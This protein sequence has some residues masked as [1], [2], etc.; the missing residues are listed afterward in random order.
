MTIYNGFRG[1]DQWK[2]AYPPEYD[3]LQIPVDELQMAVEKLGSSRNKNC[4]MVPFC[5]KD[6][7]LEPN[8]C[9]GIKKL[10]YPDEDTIE[11]FVGGHKTVCG[12]N[13][14]NVYN[15]PDKD[16]EQWMEVCQ[17]AVC[18]C[19]TVEFDGHWTGDDWS[20]SFNDSLLVNW[21][22]R[23]LP[24][25]DV[26]YDVEKTA[27]KVFDA[28]IELVEKKYEP[29]WLLLDSIINSIYKEAIEKYGE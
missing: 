11:V 27:R 28:A 26:D 8:G 13:Q 2:T 23:E 1:Y 20:L 24:D 5:G 4:W 22:Y 15:M 21:E 18:G 7:D 6:A 12:V 14:E 25:G 29:E 16:V 10:R 19:G 17:E 3:Y 9:T